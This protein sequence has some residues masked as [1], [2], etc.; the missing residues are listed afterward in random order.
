MFKYEQY[1][2]SANYIKEKMKGKNP[3]TA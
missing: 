3:K 1:V 2:E